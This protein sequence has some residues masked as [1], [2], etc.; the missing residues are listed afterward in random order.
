[1]EVCER[2]DKIE[3]K[4]DSKF[5]IVGMRLGDLTMLEKR[6]STV[7]TTYEKVDREMDAFSNALNDI[8]VLLERKLDRT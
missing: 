3:T 1:M 7:E 8:R 5:E 6:M 4:H 2:V